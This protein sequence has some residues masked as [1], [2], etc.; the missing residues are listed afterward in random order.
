MR[1]RPADARRRERD[2]LVSAVRRLDETAERALDVVPDPE[3]R[4]AE[5]ADVE[6]DPHRAGRYDEA[7]E[8]RTEARGSGLP[9]AVTFAG[10]AVGDTV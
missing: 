9:P 1:S 4:M 5:R 6:R 3:Q 7:V 2:D 10:I 8:V